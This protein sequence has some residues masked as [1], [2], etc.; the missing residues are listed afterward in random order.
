METL[1]LTGIW[2]L[3]PVAALIG[4]TVFL[5]LSLARGW[6]IPKS[7]LEREM[8]ASNK[9]GDEWKETALDQRELISQQSA[10]ISTLTEATK[11]PAEFFGTVMREGGARRVVQQEESPND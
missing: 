3:S 5:F 4:V 8:A 9:R 2:G 7:S 11:T 6:V 10:Q 1:D